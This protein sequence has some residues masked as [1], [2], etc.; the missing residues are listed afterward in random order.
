MTA[1]RLKKPLPA[2]TYNTAIPRLI[3]PHEGSGVT[4]S[5][6]DPS[7]PYKDGCNRLNS[8]NRSRARTFY[9]PDQWTYNTVEDTTGIHVIKLPTWR[10][11]AVTVFD[12]RRVT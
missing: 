10:L 2:I 9:L 12:L 6:P 7:P 11:W 5:S 3:K 1:R 8:L 4:P